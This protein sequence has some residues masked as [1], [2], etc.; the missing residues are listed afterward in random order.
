MLPVQATV[1]CM[2]HCLPATLPLL[3][4]P[5]QEVVNAL[6]PLAVPGVLP[7]EVR[8]RLCALMFD[9]QNAL[10][11]PPQHQQTAAAGGG[12]AALGAGGV[13]GQSALQLLEEA[14]Q[15]DLNKFL[16]SK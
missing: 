1:H 15:G 11:H 13:A 16:F 7:P 12:G 4:L 14:L 2:P 10:L 8:M 6:R 5:T 9:L 3:L